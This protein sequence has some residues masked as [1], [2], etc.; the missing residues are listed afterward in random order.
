[1]NSPHDTARA[2]DAL[3]AAG[4]SPAVDSPAAPAQSTPPATSDSPA[5]SDGPLII[6]NNNGV[7]TLTL[8][9][10]AQYNALSEELLDAL[11]AALD[12][13]A[14]DESVRVVVLAAAGKAFCA[15]HDLKQMRA[16]DNREYQLALFAKCS[17]VMTRL[18]QLPQPVIAR[19]HGMATAAGCQLVASCDLA[20]AAAGAQFAV[21]G[22][23]VGLFCSTPAVALSRNV[24]RKRAMEMLLTGD[25][26]DA[27][28]ARE[29]GLV[30]RVAAAAELDAAVDELARAIA[31]KPSRVIQLGKRRF[32]EQLKL[33]LGDAY[34]LA[35]ATMADNM[36][37]DET[38][39]GIDAFIEKRKPNWSI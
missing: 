15:G 29:Y 23:R 10:P 3:A 18:P 28:A 5:P 14:A 22:V 30:N 16:H 19:V 31:A 13:A 21:S 11:A 7:Q 20:V 8:N 12:R 24:A 26:I 27:A 2:A 4:A 38:R 34:Q 6:S 32:Y 1:M 37:F 9:R 35:G 36:L 33:G 25:F 17:A 39:E